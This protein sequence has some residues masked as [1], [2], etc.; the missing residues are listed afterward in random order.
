[1]RS[2]VKQVKIRV[3]FRNGLGSTTLSDEYIHSEGPVQVGAAVKARHPDKQEYVDAVV[4]KIQVKVVQGSCSR[5]YIILILLL[6]LSVYTIYRRM[7]SLSLYYSCYYYLQDQSQYTVVF[8]DGDITTLRRS[9]LCMKSG[10]HFN[11][12]ESL[13]NL[14]LT[15]PEHFSTP[16]SGATGATNRRRK[17]QGAGSNNDSDMDYDSS[18]SDGEGEGS[19]EV[20]VATSYIQN[21]GRVVCVENTDKKGGKSRETWF[22]ALIVAPSASGIVKIDTKEDYLIRSFKDGR[23]YTVSKSDTT[24]FHREA[25]KKTENSHLK[26]A[27]EKAINYIE[28]EELPAHWEKDN[29]FNVGEESTTESSETESIE[30]D[31]DEESPEEKDHLVAELYKH[32]EDRGSPINKTPS[33]G[34]KELDLYRLFR[35]VYKLGGHVRVSN[36]N[37]WRQVA[38]KLGFETT[39]CMNQVR[40]SYTYSTCGRKFRGI[41]GFNLCAFLLGSCSLHAVSQELRR[42]VPDFGLHPAKYSLQHLAE[43]EILR[44]PFRSVGGEGQ[45]QVWTHKD[46]RV[47]QHGAGERQVQHR[48]RTGGQD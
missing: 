14:P 34:N 4:N 27:M 10:K 7:S 31:E 37:L 23:Y 30:E 3:T 36:N 42:D 39:W 29:L 15:H 12:S 1:M 8:D 9:A 5:S 13:D 6:L 2:V 21:I 47:F 44:H 17:A 25:I 32:M 40:E 33:I 46:H 38:L 11:A 45:A 28:K 43:P 16:V 18:T 20:T 24:R 41:I 22:P 35:I 48:Q 19:D 26:D